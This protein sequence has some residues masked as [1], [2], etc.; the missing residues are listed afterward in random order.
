MSAVKSFRKI[1]PRKNALI[2]RPRVTRFG[3]A[4]IGND[5]SYDCAVLEDGR[6]SQ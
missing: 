2:P 6:R 5:I 1:N 4:H 3:T